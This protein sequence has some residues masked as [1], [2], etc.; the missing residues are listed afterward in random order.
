MTKRI[1]KGIADIEHIPNV[2]SAIAG[3]LRR[4]GIRD[5][6]DLVG[7]DP[8]AMYSDLCRKTRQRHD[9]CVIDV[10]IAA[11]RFMQ[12][13]P[14]RPWWKYTAERKRKLASQAESNGR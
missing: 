8:Y 4:L 1:R 3:D 10:F 6:A 9:P 2:G 11:V 13:E 12:G 7:R 5:P 14:K